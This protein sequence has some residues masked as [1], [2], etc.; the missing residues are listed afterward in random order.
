MKCPTCEK[1]MKFLGF[2]VVITGVDIFGEPDTFAI[3]EVY[4]CHNCKI[5]KHE[6]WDWEY[7]DS[8]EEALQEI[9]EKIAEIPKGYIGI[10]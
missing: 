4:A 5:F 9:G 1:E 3:A 6:I 10:P 7:Y 2:D 8:E